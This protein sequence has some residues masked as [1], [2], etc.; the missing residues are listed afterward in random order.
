MWE[1]QKLPPIT[2]QS[3]WHGY[4]L[5]DWA[6]DWETFA[7]RAVKGE[8]EQSGRDTF[9]RRRGG[10]TPE[11]PVRAG[12]GETREHGGTPVVPL[13]SPARTHGA[14]HPGPWEGRLRAG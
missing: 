14:T 5:G 11:A 6:D 4:S 1:E 9:A 12:E 13:S 7:R 10:G 3:P 2:P 8:W